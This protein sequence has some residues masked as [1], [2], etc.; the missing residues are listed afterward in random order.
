MQKGTWTFSV[1]IYNVP[2]FSLNLKAPYCQ[3]GAIDDEN[4]YFPHWNIAYVDITS[5]DTC[6]EYIVQFKN[7]YKR[8]IEFLSQIKR[9]SAQY[10]SVLNYG[11]PH[12]IK[13]LITIRWQKQSTRCSNADTSI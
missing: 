1:L 3:M 7:W 12:G 4:K 5:E 11:I 9:I 2:I 13:H 8:F 6:F 10:C